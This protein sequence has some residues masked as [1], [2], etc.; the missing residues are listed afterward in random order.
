[1]SNNGTTPRAHDASA[2]P[3]IRPLRF[4]FAVKVLGQEGLKSND[5]RRWQS[6]PHLS[7]SLGYLRDI[8]DYLRKTDIT[9]YRMTSDLAPY[10]THPDMPQ[11]HNQIAE[12]A[13]ELRALGRTA[14]EQDLRLSM[15]PSQFVV[16]NSPDPVLVEKSVRDLLAGA[17]ILDA[18]ELGPEAVLVI[19][20]GG[21]Y[22]DHK[23]GCQRWVETYKTLPEPVRRRL[24]L[25]NDDIRYSAADVLDIHADTGVPLIFDYQHF[26][27]N[28]PESL[29]LRLTLERFVASWPADRSCKI[30]Y[31]SPNANFREVQQR[32]RKTGKPKKAVLPPIWT[33][34]ADFISPFEFI[35]FM[36]TAGGLDFDVMLEAKAKDL[37]LL[38]LRR[39]L[40]RY[41][42][43]VAERFGLAADP[44]DARDEDVVEEVLE[45]AAGE[46]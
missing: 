39:D 26:W 8:F 12:C 30:H 28:N 46:E 16:M 42:P 44:P 29:D 18:M 15:H 9:M 27:C 37:A 19:H 21:T 10:V 11:F 4:G 33:G 35:T 22:N 32:D 31:S 20:V 13:D 38:R 25:E 2:A 36:R 5:T 34:H 17:E 43:D 45:A 3:A 7:V 1:M 41:A 40:P 6:D 23:S 24:V 14:R